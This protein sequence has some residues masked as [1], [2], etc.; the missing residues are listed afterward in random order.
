[1]A[2]SR[3]YSG[4]RTGAELRDLM[5]TR[6]SSTTPDTSVAA[7]AA[8]MATANVGSAV[9]MQ[10]TF[11]A[12]ILTERDVL[13]AAA[14]GE[15]LSVSMVSQWM[16]PD[17]Q[18]ASPATSVEDAAQIMLLNGFRHLPVVEGRAV[19]GVVSLR[20]LFAARIRRPLAAG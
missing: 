12:G 3:R 11:L 2:E 18:S 20:D 16:T 15:D 5:N 7:A 10:G 17:P 13:R 19:C 8:G 1:M 6:V 9:V 14:S 4:A